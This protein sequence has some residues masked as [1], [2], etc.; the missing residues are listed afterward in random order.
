[1]LPTRFLPRL[2]L[3]R[4]LTLMREHKLVRMRPMLTGHP[5]PRRRQIPPQNGRPGRMLLPFP[6]IRTNMVEEST[7]R[8]VLDHL[9]YLESP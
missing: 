8:R 9:A 7:L 1:M 4:H 2:F 3:H 5:R 6:K